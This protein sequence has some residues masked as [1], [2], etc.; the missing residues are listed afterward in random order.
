MH[1]YH[2]TH[3]NRLIDYISSNSDMRIISVVGP[4]QV[5]KTIIALQALQRLIELGFT[6]QYI[7][8]DDPSL[9]EPHCVRDISRIDIRQIENLATPMN[10]VNIWETARKASLQSPRG[11]VLFLD[12]VQLVRRWSNYVKG[13]WDRD[14]LEGHP[15]HIVIL[16][17]AA[18]QMLVG[19][20]EGLTGRFR[21]LSVTHWS[22]YEMANVFGLTVDQFMFYGGYPASWPSE[23]EKSRFDHWRKYIT[24]SIVGSVTG[25][26]IPLLN[27]IRKPVLMRQLMN[28]APSYSG[29]IMTYSKFS[30]LL[31]DKGSAKTVN[32]YI[33]LLSDAGLI[34]TLFRYTPYFGM[35]SPPKLSVLNT[36]LMTAPSGYSFQ[37]A[38]EDRPFWGRVVAS[39]IGAHLCNTRNTATRIHYWR[40]KSNG[41]EVDFVISRGPHLVGVEVQTGKK[42]THSGLD[43][44]ESCFPYAKTMIV[45]A[46]GVPFNEFLLLSADNWIEHL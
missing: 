16:G 39:A 45:G 1:N 11:H 14:R 34:T 12:E 29:Q 46:G 15:L 35:A 32:H 5:G 21:E 8:F 6:C 31:H 24:K 25:R 38:Q 18:W 44:F 9:S 26:D 19:P 43:A 41:H 37:E 33:D 22:L 13:L 36:A 4:R 2:R 17:S 3:V 30:E 7:S 23:S 20:N 10:L 42:Q 27:Q 40:D 28:I